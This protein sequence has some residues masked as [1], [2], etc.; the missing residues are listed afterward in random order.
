MSSFCQI[1]TW[2]QRSWL[3]IIL[4]LITALTLVAC[5][6]DSFQSKSERVPQLLFSIDSDPRTFNAA[7]GPMVHDISILTNEGLVTITQ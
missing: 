1:F 3:S 5:N 6:I 4:A 2:I 7:Y